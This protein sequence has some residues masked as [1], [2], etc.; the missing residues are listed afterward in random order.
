[1]AF[2]SEAV[3]DAAEAATG[4]RPPPIARMTWAEALDRYGTDKPD[5]RF[6]MELVDLSRRVRGDRGA[7]PSRSPTVKALAC[8]G[9]RRLPP[10]PARR[11]DRA[12][13]AGRRGG[14]GLVPG[15]RRPG[16]ARRPSIR[17]ST[18]S[19]PTRRR[20]ALLAATEGGSR[21]T[22]SWS[23][24]TSTGWPARCSARSA[25]TLG[26][27]AGERGSAPLRLGRRLPDVRRRRR[28]RHADAG[29]PPLHHAVPRGPAAAGDRSRLRCARRPTTSSS[30]GGSWDRG[31]CVSTAATSRSRC[32]PRS[33]I[34]AEEAEAR[35]GFLLGAFR[36]G[37][38]PHAGFAV[39][40]RPPGGHPG[41]GGEHPR[42]HRLPE[43]PVGR[44]PAHRR[45][46]A[47]A[48]GHAWPSWASGSWPP[49]PCHA[50]ARSAT[51]VVDRS[52]RPAG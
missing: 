40:R 51:R 25:S 37:A 9:R 34:D 14:P 24:P 33:G 4:E 12:G 26:R 39:R 41:R 42:G 28:R 50:L 16:T 43:D 8:R 46:D 31:A 22:S 23:S 3:L 36:Y 21:A 5:L 7:R 30:T 2:V 48:R 17:R 27:A 15:H 44:R 18:D 20:S 29:A 35:F 38:P 10:L 47:A 49:P 32:S 6:G 45:A 13:Q 52:H 19:S 11:P 1:M